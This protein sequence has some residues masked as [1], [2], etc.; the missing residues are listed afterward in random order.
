MRRSGTIVEVQ[1][2]ALPH[3]RCMPADDFDFLQGPWTIENVLC[4][5]GV[6][7]RFP[8][9][10]FGLQ[11]HMG[12][13]VNTD[14]CHFTPPAPRPPFRGMS[15]RL[16]SAS[17]GQW[18]IYWISDTTVDLSDPVRGTFADGVGT[19]FSDV[20]SVDGT[21]CRFLWTDIDGPHPHWKESRSADGGTTW[22]TAWTM[23]FSRP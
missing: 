10:H 4:R 12:G 17:T 7:W 16:L 11:K 23:D 14:V 18:S 2:G 20:D 13:I 1:G 21:V 8:G 9:E 6:A 5:D 19:F 3:T 15:V 22:T